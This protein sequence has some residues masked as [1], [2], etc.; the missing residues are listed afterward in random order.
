MPVAWLAAGAS[1]D[2]LG[3][4]PIETITHTT[5]DWA[6]RFLLASLAVTPLR[7]LSGWNRLIA[8]R[9]T[10]GLLAFAYA[11]LHVATYAVLDHWFDWTAILADVRQRPYVTAGALAATCLVPLAVTSTRGWIRRLGRRWTTLH[12]LAYVAAVAAVTHYWWL[13]KAD[14]RA[15]RWYGAVLAAL[16]AARALPALVRRRAA[17][18]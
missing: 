10:L 16:L 14:V 8:Y 2:A 12:R 1:R 3:A 7:R 11:A 18:A 13:V 9:R 15:P 6:L 5:G 4:N 17:A